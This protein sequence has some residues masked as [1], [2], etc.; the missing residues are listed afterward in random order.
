MSA[1]SIR[2]GHPFARAL[3]AT[4]LIAWVALLSPFLIV[5]LAHFVATLGR[6]ES[7]YARAIYRSPML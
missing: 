1:N 2:N 3:Q 4:A 5:S 7:L 6:R